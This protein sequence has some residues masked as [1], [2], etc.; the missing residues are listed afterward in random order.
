MARRPC[1]GLGSGR[2][3]PASL[4]QPEWP[5][6]S[7]GAPTGPGPPS[8]PGQSSAVAQELAPVSFL[9]CG[10]SCRA[11]RA[12]PARVLL[13]GH[14]RVA[15]EAPSG[16]GAPRAVGA[17]WGPLVCPVLQGPAAP[18]DQSCVAPASE[19]PPIP[20]RQQPWVSGRESSPRGTHVHSGTT[21][22]LPGTGHGLPSGSHTPPL[23]A[24][25]GGRRSVGVRATWPD[26]PLAGQRA[27]DGTLRGEAA[28]GHGFSPGPST[29]RLLSA[30]PWMC[31]APGR[32]EP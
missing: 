1:P 8:L 26:P 24:R 30:S 32:R 7:T 13:G 20:R 25:G 15:S 2:C 9:V 21:S 12:S 14:M 6:L 23:C 27:A 17:A 18:R 10:T 4:H 28:E 29:P 19:A 31:R 11:G 16:R 5:S 3:C 22:G